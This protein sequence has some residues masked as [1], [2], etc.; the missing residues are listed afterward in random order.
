MSIKNELFEIT[1]QVAN[2]VYLFEKA[3]V[4]SNDLAEHL[5]KKLSL[6]T[7]LQISCAG[8]E[9]QLLRIKADILENYIFEMAP[10]LEDLQKKAEELYNLELSSG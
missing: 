10:V 7:P 5:N 1:E 8:Q 6:K 3:Q 4:L 9:M 2:V